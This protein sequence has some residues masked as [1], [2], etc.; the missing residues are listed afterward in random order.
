MQC[1]FVVKPP[2][3]WQINRDSCASVA[4]FLGVEA[5]WVLAV[6]GGKGKWICEPDVIKRGTDCIVL[7]VKTVLSM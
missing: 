4:G 6:G 2:K 7:D 1:I 3:N 5:A